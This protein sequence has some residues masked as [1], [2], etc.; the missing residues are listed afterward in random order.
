MRVNNIH[1]SQ[2]PN[3]TEID[4][5][6]DGVAPEDIRDSSKPS[7]SKSA[8]FLGRKSSTRFM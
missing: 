1:E 8:K 4:Q 6:I 2:Q 7:R 3:M 5:I